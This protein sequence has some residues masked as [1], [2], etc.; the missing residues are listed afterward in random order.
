MNATAS[1]NADAQTVTFT[2][3]KHLPAGNYRLDIDYSGKIY[4]QAAGLFALDYE[5]EGK[6][7]RALFTQ[8]EAADARHVI[9]R[10][11]EPI[12]KATFDLTA[13]LP[14]AQ[15]AISNMPVKTRRE[16]GGGKAEV[17]SRPGERVVGKGCLI[18]GS[19]RGPPY[20]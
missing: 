1:V 10:W 2:F 3:P 13:V 11:D 5:A 16:L 7:K 8:F 6:K 17:T 9:P 18:K 4:T 19:S 20:I 15:L 12:Y 14:A